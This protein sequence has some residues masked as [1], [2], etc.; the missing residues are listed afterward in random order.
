MEIMAKLP[1]FRR[2]IVEDYNEED[3]ELVGK[4]AYSVNSFADNILN[5]LNNGL[6]I[7]DNLAQAK[8]IIRV[9]T[10]S[11]VPTQK[12]TVQTGLPGQCG[13]T[14]VIKAV[15]KTTS[16]N[17]P[18]SCPFITFTNV[19]GAIIISNITGLQDDDVYNLTVIFFP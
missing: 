14:Q 12:L 2:I 7:D 6:T 4:L 10:S 16:S 15:N 18:T 13:G 19:A 8:K 1:S 9:T 3:R 5:A 17:V 11:G